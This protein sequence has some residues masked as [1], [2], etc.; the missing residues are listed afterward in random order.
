MAQSHQF[1]RVSVMVFK[2]LAWVALGL[3][4][5][6]GLFVIITGGEPQ[7]VGGAALSARAVGFL[8]LIYGGTSFFSLWLMGSLLRLLLEIRDRLPGGS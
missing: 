2:V 6:T 7:V 1:L 8:I 3:L 5:I 4:A